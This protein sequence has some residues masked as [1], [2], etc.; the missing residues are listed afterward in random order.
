M[1]MQLN[2]QFVCPV[3]RGLVAERS[4]EVCTRLGKSV[5]PLPTADSATH[6]P[7]KKKT[8]AAA[9]SAQE[10]D[11]KQIAGQFYKQLNDCPG[12]PNSTAKRRSW[13]GRAA[14]YKKFY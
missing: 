10:A 4:A 3:G 14:K 11:N 1:R 12:L 9:V 8:A 5:M 13:R 6:C 7:T 2:G